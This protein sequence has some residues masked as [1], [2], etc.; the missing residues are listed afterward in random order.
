MLEK[1]AAMNYLAV[2]AAGLATFL[3]GGIW[4]MPLFGK[5]WVRLSGITDEKMKQMQARVPP[6]LFFGG[7]IA[8]YLIAALVVALLVVT[9]DLKHPLSDGLVLGLCLFVLVSAYAFTS[10][11]ASD[12]HYGL[13]AIE[14]SFYLV[15]LSFQGV[16]LT[17]WR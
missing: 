11:L 1:F 15:A 13:Y 5:L 16:L 9:L 4:Y 8:A 14:A 7:M 17:W 6:P 2:L 12:R 10:Q 3:L